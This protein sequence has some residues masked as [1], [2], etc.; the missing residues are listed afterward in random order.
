[1]TSLSMQNYSASVSGNGHW[2]KTLPLPFKH[3]ICLQKQF[4]Q[5][6]D[7]IE[8]RRSLGFDSIW[9]SHCSSGF[10]GS[11][12]VTQDGLKL[13][14]VLLPLSPMHYNYRHE[15]QCPPLVCGFETVLLCMSGILKFK[16]SLL[17]Y[18]W[19]DLN[20]FNYS[21]FMH[22]WASCPAGLSLSF[23][24]MSVAVPASWFGEK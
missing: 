14:V 3:M 8:E 24:M 17:H 7:D 23:L 19:M 22:P 2:Y 9:D 1:M 21:P 10:P 13:T 6:G 4:K 12:C 15:P 11:Q 20:G 5:N 18:H 16:T